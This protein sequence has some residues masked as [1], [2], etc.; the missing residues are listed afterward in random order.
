MKKEYQTPTVYALGTV[1][2]LTAMPPMDQNKCAGSGDSLLP[3][4]D[5]FTMDECPS[6]GD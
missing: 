3:A 1:K 6:T 4:Q 5:P 2:D